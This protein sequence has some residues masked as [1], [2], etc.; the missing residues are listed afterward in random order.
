MAINLKREKGAAAFRRLLARA[1]VVIDSF[2]AGTMEKLGFDWERMHGDAPR[3]IRLSLPGWG[4]SGPYQGYVSFGGG[5]DCVTGHTAVRGYPWR[6]VEET[7]PITHSRRDGAARHRLRGR[8]R[9][10]RARAHGRGD[11]CRPLAGGGTREPKSPACSPSG[12]STGASRRASATAEQHVVP[13]DCYRASGE[14]RWVVLA[15]ED[16]AQWGA[17]ARAVGHPE[18]AQDGHPWATV[19]GRL[20][21]REAVDRALAEHA[22]GAEAEALADLVQ[23]EG[24][25]AAAVAGPQEM[26]LSPQ[27]NARSW[28]PTIEHPYTGPRIQAGFLWRFGPDTLSWDLPCGLVGEY[29]RELLREHGYDDDEIDRL[30]ADGVIGNAYG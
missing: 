7:S 23:E 11:A 4:L 5:F 24:G 8:D 15:A 16:D 26:L 25:I 10:A 27:L 18:W 22:A 14:D 3:L 12:P 19:V 1:D 30:E 20:R 6:G 17:L 21:D 13:H 28:F 2:S 9:A 29:N